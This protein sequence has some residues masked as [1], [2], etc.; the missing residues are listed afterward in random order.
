M[1]EFI[2]TP[3]TMKKRDFYTWLKNTMIQAGWE[4]ISSR[5][6]TDNDVM[7]SKGES[8]EENLYIRMKEYYS[9][10]SNATLS[11]AVDV[12][13]SVYPIRS[14]IPG[15]SGSAGVGN[16]PFTTS[17]FH[18][19]RIARSNTHLDTEMTVY[20]HCNKDRIVFVVE[21]SSYTEL[22]A[23][24]FLLGKPTKVFAKKPMTSLSAALCGYGYSTLNSVSD[25]ADINPSNSAFSVTL[26]YLNTPLSINLSGNFIASEI[27]VVQK[28]DG[29]HSTLD[30]IYAVGGDN[31]IQY[32]K[33]MT[34]HELIDED[35]RVYRL[36]SMTS[37]HGNYNSVPFPFIAFRIK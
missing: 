5:P 33:A 15:N 34:G 18:W 30:G 16:P 28:D 37:A 35:G 23:N 21:W 20:Y 1:S 4:N 2:F 29:L 7:Y 32:P 10:S 13:L 31:K 11:N 9:T 27:G 24:F 6:A 19:G 25:V 26:T 8:G 36:S 14:Y 12:Y 3:A 17:S 22:D